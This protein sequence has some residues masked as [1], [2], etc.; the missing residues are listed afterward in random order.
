MD[1]RDLSDKVE[2]ISQIYAKRFGIDRD[3]DWFVFKL[4]EEMGELIQ[5]Y[6]MRTGRGR[7][8]GRTAEDMKRDFDGEVADVLSHVLILAKHFDVDLEKAVEEKWLRWKK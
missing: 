4:Q 5:I 2:E 7:Q 8:K 3:A 6:L 1:I